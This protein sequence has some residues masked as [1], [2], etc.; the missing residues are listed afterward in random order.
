[1]VST[2]AEQNLTDEMGKVSLLYDEIFPNIVAE[3]IIGF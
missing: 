1:M 3:L 2:T